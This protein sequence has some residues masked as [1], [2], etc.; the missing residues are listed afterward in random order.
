M[1]RVVAYCRVSTDHEDQKNSLENQRLYF[2]EYVSQHKGWKLVEIYADEGISGTSLKKRNDF[3]RMYRERLKNKYDIILTKEVCRFARNT[4]D[5]L[6]ITRELKKSG[7]E[8][9]F[10]IDNISTFDTDGELRLTIMAGMAQDESRRIS[11]RVQFGVIQSMK[12]GVAFGN[13]IY[14]YEYTRDPITG[15]KTKLVVNEKEAKIVNDIFNAYLYEGK[16][17]YTI[18]KE[19]KEKG[20][21]IKRPRKKEKST[22]WRERTILDMLQNVKYIGDLKQRITYTTDFL[23]HTKKQNKGEVDFIYVENHHKAIIDKK[24]FEDTQAEIKR[25]SNIYKHDKSKYTNKHTFSSKL[26][27]ACCGMSYVGGENRKRKDGSIRKTWRCYNATK[28]GKKH[29]ENEQ[30]V[31]CDNERVNDEVLKAIFMESFKEI[32]AE[33]NEIQKDIEI[34]I[35]K[36]VGKCESETQ[37]VDILLGEQQQLKKEECRLLDLY[38]KE[39]IDVETYQNKK[40]EIVN[41]LS[42]ING[43]LEQQEQKRKLKENIGEIIENAKKVVNNILTL[44]KFSDN[45]CKELVDKIIIYNSKKFDVYLKGYET[46]YIFD[47]KSNISYLPHW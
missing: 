34:Q 43:Q 20:V 28:Y 18:A 16:G 10:I 40:Q 46:P 22:D 32:I 12:K 17:A 39:I 42:N 25:R 7:I 24:L 6:E 21:T 27:C 31:G 5:T 26:V 3:N 9:K 45:V 38:L 2:E 30:E 15:K 47:D 41:K 13:I 23:E 11:E 36:V 19:L 35:K 33:K 4:V 8:V 44:K 29:I 1:K 14:G 37:L